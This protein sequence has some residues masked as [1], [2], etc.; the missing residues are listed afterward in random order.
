MGEEGSPLII[1]KTIAENREKM[2]RPKEACCIF[3][4]K[5]DSNFQNLKV[6][7]DKEIKNGFRFIA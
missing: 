4:E 5:N 6:E 1:I 2:G 3:I 7:I